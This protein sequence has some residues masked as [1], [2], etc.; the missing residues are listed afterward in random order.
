M[1]VSLH[2]NNSSN[3]KWLNFKIPSWSVCTIIPFYHVHQWHI[4]GPLCSNCIVLWLRDRCLTYNSTNFP[5]LSIV[6]PSCFP[7]HFVCDLDY[8]SFNCRH[9]IDPMGINLLCCA[10]GNKCIETH[11]VI[12]DTFVASTRDANF[13]MGWEQL[14]PLPSTTFNSF[15]RSIDIVFTKND[16][17]TLADIVIVDPTWTYLF[18]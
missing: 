10:H 6:F 16:I 2:L 17:H 14:H 13:H 9:R 5:N 12:C 1:R 15:C 11:D 4:W 8:P 18:P 3:N 7:L